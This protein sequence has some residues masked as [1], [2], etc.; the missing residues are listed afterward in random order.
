MGDKRD[1]KIDMCLGKFLSG[2]VVSVGGRVLWREVGENGVKVLVLR[3][4]G[5]MNNFGGGWWNMG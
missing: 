5:V 3:W 2:N 4:G 1:V